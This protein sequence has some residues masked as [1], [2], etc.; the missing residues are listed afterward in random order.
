MRPSLVLGAVVVPVIVSGKR[1]DDVLP[2][3]PAAVG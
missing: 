2:F 1:A 3:E